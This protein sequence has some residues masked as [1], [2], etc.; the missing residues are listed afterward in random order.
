VKPYVSKDCEVPR[1]IFRKEKGRGYKKRED[2]AEGGGARNIF[3]V[4]S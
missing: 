1:I 4:M 3:L 2:Q